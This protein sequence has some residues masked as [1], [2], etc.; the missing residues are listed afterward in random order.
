[1]ARLK[2]ERG[3]PRGGPGRMPIA[4]KYR[5]QL[6]AVERTFA[7]ALPSLAQD[8]VDELR[9][10]DPETCPEHRRALCWPQQPWATP[11]WR[12]AFYHK[13]AAYAFC[14]G[15]GQPRRRSE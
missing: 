6:S 2:E 13:A 15:L 4:E 14:R 8:Y 12:P 10:K 9:V 5:R 7:D 3:E 11:R 1:M